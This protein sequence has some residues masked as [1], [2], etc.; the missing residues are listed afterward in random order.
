MHS[1]QIGQRRRGHI[2]LVHLLHL[3]RV[4]VSLLLGY[5]TQSTKAPLLF[6][7]DVPGECAALPSDNISHAM[8]ISICKGRDK[9]K[10]SPRCDECLFQLYQKL[11][12][13][14]DSSLFFCKFSLYMK[15]ELAFFL[16]LPDTFSFIIIITTVFICYRSIFYITINISASSSL[17][18]PSN[19]L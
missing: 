13:F 15:Q 1:P 4:C 14:H 19:Y 11:R 7:N 6:E 2:A 9:N 18:S 17:I 12:A 5:S 16:F 3:C 10:R 8:V